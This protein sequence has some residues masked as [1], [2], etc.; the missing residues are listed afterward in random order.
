MCESLHVA[1]KRIRI[2]Y[3]LQLFY[4]YSKKRMCIVFYCSSVSSSL[5]GAAANCWDDILKLKLSWMTEERKAFVNK[6]LGMYHK[7]PFVKYRVWI[8]VCESTMRTTH[9]NC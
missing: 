9:I 2:N 8:I 3:K 4:I 7:V 5:S 1:V 6:V